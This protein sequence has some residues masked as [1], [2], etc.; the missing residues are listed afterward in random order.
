MPRAGV[1]AHPTVVKLLNG[2]RIVVMKLFPPDLAGCNETRF[3]EDSRMLHDAE[4][5]HRQGVLEF[6]QGL[7]VAFV[8]PVQQQAPGGIGEGSK[9]PSSILGISGDQIVSC[10]SGLSD[11]PVRP[12]RK[13]GEG[14]PSQFPDAHCDGPQHTDPVDIPVREFK[15]D[16]HP[17]TRLDDQRMGSRATEWRACATC[18]GQTTR[19]ATTVRGYRSNMSALGQE[20]TNALSRHG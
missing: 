14:E 17:T 2:H 12:G 11:G 1:L 8:E 10:R 19:L 9:D 20:A 5:R 3:L 4:A 6:E 16:R 18:A 15:N 7:A 13:S